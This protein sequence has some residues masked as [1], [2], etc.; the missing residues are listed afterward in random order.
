M[1]DLTDR[2]VPS[3]VRSALAEAM[4]VDDL[5][6]DRVGHRP[7]RSAM[8]EPSPDEARRNLSRL[9]ITRW[10][11]VMVEYPDDHGTMRSAWL[12]GGAIM[13]YPEHRDLLARWAQWTA[14]GRIDHDGVGQTEEDFAKTF[15]MSHST[16]RRWIEFASE[17]IADTLNDAGL[18]AWCVERPPRKNR[19]ILHASGTL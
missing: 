19:I 15:R 9:D 13:G 14:R 16:F 7:V 6:R 1:T 11:Y 8:G 17:T 12:N 10:Q 18:K 3:L 4:R 5:L 2:W